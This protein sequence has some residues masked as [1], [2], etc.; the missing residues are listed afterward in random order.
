[1]GLR[2]PKNTPTNLRLLRGNP[3]KQPI[4]PEPRPLV[5]TNVP[6]YPSYLDRYARRVWRKLAPE[7]HRLGLLTLVD[8]DNLALY[9]QAISDY[10]WSIHEQRT[11][12]RMVTASTGTKQINPAVTVMKN[13]IVTIKLVSAMFGLSP[14]TRA[15]LS[16][17]NII[18]AKDEDIE[19]KLFG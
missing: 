9:C 12:G 11:N 4:T 6:K 2:G 16:S 10:R 8:C 17:Q 1:M 3:S 13:S 18:N 19:K 14:S 15:G 7:L 5:S